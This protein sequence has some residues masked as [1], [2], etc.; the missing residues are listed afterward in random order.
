MKRPLTT[1][2]VPC[3]TANGTYE[4][5]LVHCCSLSYYFNCFAV[6]VDVVVV[7]I[8]VLMDKHFPAVL[9]SFTFYVQV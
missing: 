1:E 3:A 6:V 4:N 9:Y 5:H 2:H 8:L 7:I